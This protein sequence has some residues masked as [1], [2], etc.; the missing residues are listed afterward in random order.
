LR[1][2]SS[3]PDQGAYYHPHFLRGLE[4]RDQCRFIRRIKVKGLGPRKPGSPATEPNFYKFPPLGM[5]PVLAARVTGSPSS[6]TPRASPPIMPYVG[7]GG[8][9]LASGRFSGLDYSSWAS[10]AAHHR[11]A[12]GVPDSSGPCSGSSWMTSPPPQGLWYTSAAAGSFPGCS[13]M[14][15]SW[16]PSALTY[17]SFPGVVGSSLPFTK[18]RASQLFAI[19]TAI[20]SGDATEEGPP[21]GSHPPTGLSTTRGPGRNDPSSSGRRPMPSPVG[22]GWLASSRTDLGPYR[23]PV[24]VRLPARSAGLPSE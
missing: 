1:D 24:P 8:A 20:A 14:V 11:M 10:K 6:S 9:D 16:R 21:G 3:G 2:A 15:G 17:P 22:P 7:M 12:H 5:R 19:A 4:H 13:T 18:L 23:R